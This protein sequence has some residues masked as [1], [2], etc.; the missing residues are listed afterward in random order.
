MSRFV[1]A[2]GLLIASYW[3]YAPRQTVAPVPDVKDYI[4]VQLVITHSVYAPGSKVHFKFL[5]T[6]VGEE[7]LYLYRAGCGGPRAYYEVEIREKS[8]DPTHAGR[9]PGRIADDFDWGG[10]DVVRELND[11]QFAIRLQSNE[12]YGFEDDIE[13]PKKKGV[14]RIEATFVPAGFAEEQKAALAEKKMRLPLRAVSG[15]RVIFTVN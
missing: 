7:P 9:F 3:L 4:Q 13:L 8:G 1:F 14:Y 2:L 12:I 5:V 6:N 15:N 10:R 11:P